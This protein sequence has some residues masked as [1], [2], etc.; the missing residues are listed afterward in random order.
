MQFDLTRTVTTLSQTPIVLRALLTG[1]PDEL[2]K[3]NEGGE[4]WSPF[5]VL[6]HL[7]HGEKTDWIPRARIITEEGEARSFESFDRSAQFE[8]SKG[9]TLEDLL[10]EFT[11]L[12]QENIQQLIELQPLEEDLE[13][14]GTH[15]DF[16]RVTLG[17]LL[18]TWVV[19]DYGHI[20][21]VA[22]T[23]AKQFADGVGPW[24]QYLTVLG[25][26]AT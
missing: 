16:G 8:E 1:V 2:A 26:R 23:L 24:R 14:A 12:R 15:P 19:H 21:Q 3:A 7:I 6:G 10:V 22:R 17:Q 20:A 18:D 4:S 5:D 11:N 13:K 25:D 9:K